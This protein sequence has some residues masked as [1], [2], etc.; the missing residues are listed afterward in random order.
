[1]KLIEIG[2]CT[3]NND[4]QGIGRIRYKKYLEYNAPKEMAYEYVKWD[5]KDLFIALPFL[6]L[7]INFLPEIGQAIKLIS[8]DNEKGSLNTEYISGP[9]VSQFN[10]SDQQY[11]AQVLNTTYGTGMKSMNNISN[12]E[13][14]LISKSED[15]SI[16]GKYGSDILFTSNGVQIRGGKLKSKS[17]L[18]VR[19]LNRGVKGKS[20][21]IL[22]L[23]KFPEKLELKKVTKEIEEIEVGNLSSILEYELDSLTT[24][25]EIRFYLYKIGIDYEGITKTNKFN[26]ATIIPAGMSKLIN[27]ENNSEPTITI[28]IPEDK[29]IDFNYI[30]ILIKDTIK[31]IRND[32]IHSIN[33]R[34]TKNFNMFPF[35]FR[36]SDNF[37]RLTDDTTSLGGS[38]IETISNK[39]KFGTTNHGII[40]KF[41]LIWSKDSIYPP[42]KT[43]KISYNIFNSESTENSISSLRSDIVYL[44]STSV[45]KINNSIPFDKINNYEITQQEYGELIHPHTYSMVRGESLLKL[46]KSIISV[47]YTHQHNVVGAMVKREEHSEYKE[48]ERLIQTI[49]SDILNKMIRIN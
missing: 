14:D 37:N 11:E 19:E 5:E 41:G 9:F 32:G 44:L 34:Y 2:I 36:P 18:K 20:S 42:T 35:Y 30:G 21:S 38:K 49:E 47:L 15:Y 13:R 45:D 1:M 24:P 23:S 27:I 17:N 26:T 33:K 10:Y 46:L 7:N 3:D 28:P 39:I 8:Y 25:T 6:P 43:K 12:D 4:P 40:Y 29:R 16:S 48:L 31:T 22:H